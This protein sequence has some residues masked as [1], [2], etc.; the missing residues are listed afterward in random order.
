MDS[1]FIEN[2]KTTGTL[3]GLSVAA[4]VFCGPWEN[5][6]RC[7]EEEEASTKLEKLG[8]F[9]TTSKNPSVDFV[10]TLTE[11]ERS[12][13]LNWLEQRQRTTLV[14]EHRTE[15]A[16]Y[17]EFVLQKEELLKSLINKLRRN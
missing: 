16:N 13:L 1:S 14:E 5:A 2:E 6:K 8:C 10:L 9:M 4:V 15:T 3:R 12:H 11:E 7:V 17:R